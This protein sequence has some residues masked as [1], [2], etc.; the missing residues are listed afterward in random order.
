MIV[1]SEVATKLENILNGNDTETS[2]ITGRSDF[3]FR[4]E[5][6][7]FHIDHIME[8]DVGTN[9]IPVFVG[10]MGGQ[11][12]P[13]PNLKQAEF[14]IP[15]TFYF[16]VRFKEEIFKLNDFLVSVFVGKILTYGTL[17]GKALSNISIPTYGEI[18]GMDLQ[19][20]Q[21]WVENVYQTSVGRK[22][23][24]FMSMSFNLYILQ[25]D[26]TFAYGNE[27]S[28][29]LK[30]KNADTNPATYYLDTAV[31]FADGSIQSNSEMAGQQLLDAAIPET[32]GLPVNTSYES[33][34]TVYY[35]KNS[36]YRYIID[37]WFSGKTQLLD[38]EIT[39]SFDTKTFTR[40][41]YLQSVNMSVSKGKL[42]TLTFSFAKK[43]S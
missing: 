37:K 28:V 12:N 29:S 1:L 39:M 8:K 2:T 24:P 22:N 3:I 30:V 35:K 9:F 15:I 6:Q 20:F 41:C 7:G 11:M 21:K 26:S 33:S 42:V 5:A 27:A 23:E 4:V 18:I 34:F 43:M 13:V 36:M 32:N 17:S 40:P 38:V 16:P 25:T 31:V 19:E 10:S 14:V